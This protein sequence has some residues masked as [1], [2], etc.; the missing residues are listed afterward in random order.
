LVIGADEEIYE[1]NNGCLC[2]SVRGD[3]IRIIG[4]LMKR[5]DKFDYVL[6]E[7][8]GVAGPGPVAQTFFVDD[9][10]A[11]SVVLDGIVTVVDALHV[12]QHIDVREVQEQI[13]FANV[14]LLNKADLVPDARLARRGCPPWRPR[15]RA[16]LT[17]TASRPGCMSSCT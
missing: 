9:E 5:R 11:A 12:K 6:I 16:T 2:C 3:L 1:M 4:S 13:A 8:S 15:R 7:T 10:L 17:S 14:I